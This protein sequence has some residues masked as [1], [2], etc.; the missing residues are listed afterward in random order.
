M[1]SKTGNGYCDIW[2]GLVFI[3]TLF[4]FLLLL[5]LLYFIIL[6]FTLLFKNIFTRVWKLT[7]N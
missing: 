5:L 4:S 7:I 2:C 3:S 6:L 1:A